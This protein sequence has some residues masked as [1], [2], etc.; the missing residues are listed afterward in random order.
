VIACSGYPTQFALLTLFESF[1]LR[2]LTPAGGFNMSF[3]VAVSLLDSVLLVALMIGFL[4]SHGERPRDVFLGG[5]SIGPEAAHG[6]VLIFAALLIAI[7]VLGSIQLLAPWLHNV[8]ENPLGILIQSPRDAWIFALVVIVAGGIREELQRAFLLHRF[9]GWLGGSTVGVVVTS[10][11]FGAG[12]FVQGADAVIATALLG[13]FWG[14]VY[15]RRRSVVAP[16]ISHA[17]FDLLQIVQ[18]LA[19][20]R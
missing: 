12:H 9:E 17:G 3:V 4:R 5:R 1:G 19:T 2:A 6:V 18:F 11:A 7:A 20:A 16:L 13:A 8:P 14:V 15:L 10:A